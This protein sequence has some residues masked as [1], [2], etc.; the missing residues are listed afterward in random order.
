MLLGEIP[1]ESAVRSLPQA[2][3]SAGTLVLADDPAPTGLPEQRALPPVR[4]PAGPTRST[5]GPVRT[6]RQT[7]S[8]STPNPPSPT[9]PMS[10]TP[11]AA[12]PDAPT[13]D[14]PTPGAP[15][16]G[17]SS[18]APQI[19]SPSPSPSSNP[20]PAT[21]TGAGTAA[22]A[23]VPSPDKGPRERPRTDAA[24]TPPGGDTSAG[25]RTVSSAL[26][27]SGALKSA[28]GIPGA[29]AVSF[30]DL[31]RG[32]TLGYAWAPGRTPDF[33]AETARA[34]LALGCA[35]DACFGE[36]EVLEE[37]VVFGPQYFSVLMTVPLGPGAGFG[38]VHLCLNRSTSNLAL[39]Q[40]DLRAVAACLP[41]AIAHHRAGDTPAEPQ[42]LSVPT[43]ENAPLPR[44]S[45][46]RRPG[47]NDQAP[48]FTR[49][50]PWRPTVD[51]ATLHH[52][53]EALRRLE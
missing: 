48:V 28:L 18:S 9:P 14:S 49:A 53:L 5:V 39:A 22:S 12:G 11:G 19:P 17:T 6:A 36:D 45:R 1:I 41:A 38:Y 30:G 13:S 42:P 33:P 35:A 23:P 7:R 25:M 27:E 29:L 3:P 31:T 34:L 51:E 44:R 21:S 32:E 8:T 2:E 46:H 24:S 4:G 16:A 20:S 52:I 10:P 26:A 50:A 15:T 47:P 43:G 40:M 37:A